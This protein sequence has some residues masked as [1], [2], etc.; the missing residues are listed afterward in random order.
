MKIVQLL[1][2]LSPRDAIGNDALAI[3][4]TLASAGYQCL[5]MANTVHE[6]LVDRAQRVSLTDVGK[7][8]L[9]ILHS[10]VGD[11]LIRAVAELPCRK[12][13]LYHNMTPAKYYLA[14]D[15]FLSAILALGRLQMRQ[16]VRRMDFAWGDSRYN[17]EE[18]IRCG[19]EPTRVAVLPIILSDEQES[20]VPDS[21]VANGL[22][23]CLG[24]K[25]LFIGRLSPNKKF[26]D[27]IRV[28][29]HVLRHD[30]LAR[31]FIVG[32]WTGS[33][34]YFAKLKGLC[35]DLGLS[36]YQVVFTGSVSEEEKAS[37]LLGTDVMVCMSEHEGFCV[38][39]IEAMR[40]DLPV[41]A[42][43]KAAVPETLGDNGLL[44]DSRDYEAIAD[45]VIEASSD[46]PIRR[47]AI[48]RQR[49]QLQRYDN[50]AS[51]ERLLQLVQREVER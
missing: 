30:P 26:E 19:I 36:D 28:Y 45:A 25:L 2:T 29:W 20:V 37:Y 43:A 27:I 32:S 22:G 44:F 15:P 51:R 35:A 49:V 5:I 13:V 10:A 12:G 42:R 47:H 4:E 34:K 7:D 41:V 50:A 40:N 6:S 48:E 46:T 9:V 31:L 23:K 11:S 33:G 38:P 39:I 3:D 21:T 17:C 1:P 16:Y 8:D 18:L 24:A 14:Y